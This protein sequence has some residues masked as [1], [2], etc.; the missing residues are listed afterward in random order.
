[1]DSVSNSGA[2]MRMKKLDHRKCLWVGIWKYR[3]TY[4]LTRVTTFGFFLRTASEFSAD[5]VDGSLTVE[6]ADIVAGVS[7][8]NSWLEIPISPHQEY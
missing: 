7:R 2:F 8:W 4:I 1:M 3:P 6:I 5:R